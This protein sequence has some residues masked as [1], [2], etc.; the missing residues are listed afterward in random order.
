MK[1]TKCEFSFMINDL[2][3]FKITYD[4]SMNQEKAYKIFRLD[5]VP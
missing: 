3:K 2:T 5:T 1:E 4:A